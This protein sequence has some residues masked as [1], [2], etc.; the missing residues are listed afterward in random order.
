MHCIY[1]CV[2]LSYIMLNNTNNPSKLTL[3][4]WIEARLQAVE[5]LI[6]TQLPVCILIREL[7]EGIYTQAPGKHMYINTQN[8]YELLNTVASEHCRKRSILKK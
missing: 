5:E 1:P 6:K 2:T 8:K 7:D 3:L 4:W